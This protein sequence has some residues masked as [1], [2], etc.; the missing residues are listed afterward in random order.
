MM[1]DDRNRGRCLCGNVTYEVQG[2]PVIVAHCHC[3]DC[4]R[5]SGSGHLPGAMFQESQ[6]TLTG[7]VG[8]Y[9]LTSDNGTVVTRGFCRMCGS[10][11]FGKNTGMPGFVTIT[12]GTL[13][14][15]SHLKPEVAIFSRNRKS[16]DVMDE[17]LMTF[18]AQPEWTPENS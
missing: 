4:Q 16:W 8:E 14:D 7:E 11:I 10:P 12:L 2:K 13:Q 3:V 17:S 5:L 18:A 6:F 1:V 9:A 15:S